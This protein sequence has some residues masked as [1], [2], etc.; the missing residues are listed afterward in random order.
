MHVTLPPPGWKN[1]LDVNQVVGVLRRDPICFVVRRVG[2]GLIL[3]CTNFSDAIHQVDGNTTNVHVHGDRLVETLAEV[4]L[5]AGWAVRSD[6]G[7]SWTSRA[8]G[9]ERGRA[10]TAGDAVGADT[11]LFGRCRVGEAAWLVDGEP[12]GELIGG[13]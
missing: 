10:D 3:F 8:V 9:A 7:V 2:V 1:C 6:G 11:G 13:G 5:E 12:L 4:L